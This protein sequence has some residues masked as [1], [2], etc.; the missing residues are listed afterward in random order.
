MTAPVAESAVSEARL[1]LPLHK[2]HARVASLTGLAAAGVFT[3][4]IGR[5]GAGCTANV[6]AIGASTNSLYTVPLAGGG[7]TNLGSITGMAGA[8]VAI[9]FDPVG[10]GDRT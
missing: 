2:R 8:A 10:G 6:Y 1:A 4:L 9:A 3:L 5:A 7:L